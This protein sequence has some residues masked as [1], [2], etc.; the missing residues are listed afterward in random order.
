MGAA[1]TSPGGTTCSAAA[2]QWH[3]L[4]E[5]ELR[6]SAKFTEN[7]YERLRKAKLTFGDR[8]HCPFLR[9]F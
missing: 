7:F 6:S 9:P 2:E 1:P 5:A 3:K 8:V 4:L